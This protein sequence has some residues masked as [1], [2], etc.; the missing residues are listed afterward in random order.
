MDSLEAVGVDVDRQ[1][2]CKYTEQEMFENEKR[3]VNAVQAQCIKFREAETKD[4]K[5]MTAQ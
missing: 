4:S 2:R 5:T 1:E 3:N